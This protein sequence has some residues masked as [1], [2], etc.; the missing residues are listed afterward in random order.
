VNEPGR[1]REAFERL[2]DAETPEDLELLATAAFLVGEDAVSDD[3]WTRAHQEHTERKQ[4]AAAVRCAFWL[5]YGLINRAEFAPAMGWFG[6]G[7]RIV[8]EHGLDCP[9]SGYL[10]LPVAIAMTGEDPARAHAVF[11]QALDIGSRFA[12][13]D[14]VTLARTGAGRALLRMGRSTEGVALLDEAM[15]AVTAGELSPVVTGDVYCAVLE[16][17]FEIL[18]YGRAYEW[19]T[20]LTRWCDSQP[21]LVPFRGQCLVHRAEILQMHGAWPDAL[22][23]ARQACERLTKHPMLG[24]AFYRLGEL[25]RLRG[26][27]EEAEGAYLRAGEWSR[28]PQPGLALLRLAQGQAGAAEAAIR[29]VLAASKDPSSR[30]RLLG[31]FVDIMLA[32]N[33]PDDARG[34]AE[35]LRALSAQ[36]NAPIL[37]AASDAAAGAVLL[38][39]GDAR[40]AIGV[41]REAA[42]RWQQLDVMHEA[43][44]ARVL[45]G[46]ACRQL[47]DEDGA[48]IEIQA[49]SSVFE[50]LEARPDLERVEALRHQSK[51]AGGLSPRETEVLR[52]VASGKTNRAIAS[53]LVLSEK[54]VARHVS[55]IFAKLG[56]SSRSAATAYAYEHDLV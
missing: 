48:T 22:A 44:S 50:Y 14:L 17:C 1:W 49:A 38:A 45:I 25:H 51:P 8:D 32:S 33:Q 52:L 53:D 56:V 47:G 27:F 36:L 35:E 31:A 55:N 3:A 41:L 42:S 43:A 6:R 24:E 37:K 16:G 11:L 29:R 7:Q 2:R 19:T 21:D 9:E 12:E 26:E 46:L 34:G 13:P 30:A 28:E 40:G 18:D 15:V 54:T 10:L 20:A 39:E 5:G 4:F 23:V